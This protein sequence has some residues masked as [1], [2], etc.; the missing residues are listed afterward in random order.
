MLTRG[1]WT[2]ELEDNNRDDDENY[3]T[4]MSGLL[5]LSEVLKK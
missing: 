3:E 2:N 1:K 4:D 5:A